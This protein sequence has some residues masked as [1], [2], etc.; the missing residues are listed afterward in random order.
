MKSQVWSSRTKM[1]FKEQF[2]CQYNFY[3]L[4]PCSGQLK[5]WTSERM[6]PGSSGFV[7]IAIIPAVS[8]VVKNIVPQQYPVGQECIVAGLCL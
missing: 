2:L 8:L 4:K 7:I 6:F 3:C 1:Q 5:L